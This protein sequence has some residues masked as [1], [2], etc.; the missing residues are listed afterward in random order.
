[1]NSLYEDIIHTTIDIDWI[2]RPEPWFCKATVLGVDGLMIC[3]VPRYETYGE[4]YSGPKE[5]FN[6]S[7]IGKIKRCE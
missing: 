7:L 2:R 6:L 5:W 4:V 1:V 3:L